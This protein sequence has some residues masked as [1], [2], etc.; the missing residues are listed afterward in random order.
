MTLKASRSSMTFWSEPDW[1]PH[2][3]VQ[4]VAGEANERGCAD[5]R[6]PPKMCRARSR[7]PSGFENMRQ[8][9]AISRG[10]P[11]DHPPIASACRSGVRAICLSSQPKENGISFLGVGTPR[12][13]AC[14][15]GRNLG[16]YP[17]PELDA[18]GACHHRVGDFH[19]LVDEVRSHCLDCQH[20]NGA[21]PLHRYD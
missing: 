10:F 12:G 1:A 5:A 4:A 15:A 19:F 17:H 7:R 21:K 14:Q 2:H 8:F 11:R 13:L 18:G 9:P 20:G 3:H 16:R 6:H